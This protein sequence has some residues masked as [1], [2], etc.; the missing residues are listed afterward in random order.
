M[1][2]RR[3]ATDEELLAAIPAARARAAE[4]A[5]HEPRA[6]AARF[7]SRSG[8][9]VLELSNGCILAFPPDLDEIAGLTLEERGRV[10][11]RPGGRG[12]SW[13][14]TD[15]ALSVPALLSGEYRARGASEAAD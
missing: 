6:V 3:P 15:A 11:V 13:D 4:A 9:T 14:G 8:W 5:E 7:V 1:A 2:D 10:R 12:L